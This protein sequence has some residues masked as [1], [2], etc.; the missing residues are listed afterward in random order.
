MSLFIVVAVV[1]AVLGAVGFA[2]L[3]PQLPPAVSSRR[4]L[5]AVRGLDNVFH[6]TT[7][8][9]THLPLSISL[10]LPPALSTGRV[11]ATFT[12][13]HRQLNLGPE[14]YNDKRFPP[15][16]VLVWPVRSTSSPPSD[17]HSAVLVLAPRRLSHRS[18]SNLL[19]VALNKGVE[20]SY[21]SPTCSVT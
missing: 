18:H 1:V 21:S 2:A 15:P 20:E 11:L 13:P 9:T 16:P 8:T 5:S 4:P 6:Q 14:A 7:T 12:S 17:S 3:L 10:P 19:V